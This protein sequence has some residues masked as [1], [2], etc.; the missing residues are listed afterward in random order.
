V[1]EVK[2]NQDT[3]SLCVRGC[4]HCAWLH[5]S[6]VIQASNLAARRGFNTAKIDVELVASKAVER[7]RP[8][9]IRV[10]EGHCVNEISTDHIHHMLYAFVWR[11]LSEERRRVLAHDRNVDETNEQELGDEGK[12]AQAL[13]EEIDVPR[14]RERLLQFAEANL[15]A[16]QLIILREILPEYFVRSAQEASPSR[17]V[18]EI[19]ARHGW[20]E[21]D[22]R[23][24]LH[25]AR[26]VLLG[27]FQTLID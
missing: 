13:E 16:K 5:Q 8:W 23:V 18:K 14:I 12:T 25:R 20:K 15:S 27:H 17:S 10:R 4:H 9:A 2:D 21:I 1:T 19:A 26:Q 6:A 3:T 24:T 22:V 7:F 11:T